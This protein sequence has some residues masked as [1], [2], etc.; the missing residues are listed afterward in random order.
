MEALTPSTF[1]HHTIRTWVKAGSLVSNGC[2]ED[3]HQDFSGPQSLVGTSW[4]SGSSQELWS[5]VGKL[6]LSGQEV[7]VVRP[8]LRNG[9]SEVG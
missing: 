1:M 6:L 9:A 8:G 5:A 2:L 3:P 7:A 4:L